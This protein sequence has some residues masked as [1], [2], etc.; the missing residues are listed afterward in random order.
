MPSKKKQQ[1]DL[2]SMGDSGNTSK[3][4]PAEHAANEHER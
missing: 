1:N 4:F 2:N 3:G